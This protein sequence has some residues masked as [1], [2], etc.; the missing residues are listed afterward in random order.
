MPPFVFSLGQLH[1]LTSTHSAQLAADW[2][3]RELPPGTSITQLW[4]D[5]PVLDRER[6]Q[7]RL[8]EDPFELLGQPYTRLSS[9][10]VIYDNLPLLPFRREL[11]EDLARHYQP[12]AHFG[13]KPRIGPLVLPE[14]AAAH[15]WKYTH[16]E[17]YI[18]RRVSPVSRQL[19]EL[20]DR[21]GPRTVSGA[22]SPPT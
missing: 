21:T 22:A 14:P 16:P 3:Q 18:F 7:V 12:V 17:I 8:M 20:V 5:Y 11:Y 19:G 13:R 9:D 1:L 4:Y 6:Y 15:D 10:A 2:V